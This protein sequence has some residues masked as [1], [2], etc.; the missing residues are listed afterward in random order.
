MTQK[1]LRAKK[2]RNAM[3]HERAG[4]QA[5]NQSVW[6]SVSYRHGAKDFKDHGTYAVKSIKE[7]GEVKKDE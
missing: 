4:N 6:A 1:E 7:Y 3:L 2:A 5:F